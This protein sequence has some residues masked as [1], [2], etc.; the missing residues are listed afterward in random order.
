[1]KWDEKA[2]ERL[3]RA[4]F[5]VRRMIKKK[6]EKDAERRGV[7]LITSELVDAIKKNQHR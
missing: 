1:M 2:E 4:P 7:T 6:I 3:Q 5:F